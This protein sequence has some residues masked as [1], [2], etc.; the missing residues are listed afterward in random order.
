MAIS[1]KDIRDNRQWRASTGLNEEQFFELVKEFKITYENFL[2]ESVS[3][4]KSDT[5]LHT[6]E[7]LVFFILYSIKSGLTYD[8]LGLSFDMDRG[9]VFRQQAFL[10][11]ILEMT[12]QRLG[13]MPKRL[14]Q[15]MQ[16]FQNHME[17]EEAIILDT[18]EQRKQRSQNQQVQKKEYSGKKKHIL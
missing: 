9:G 5:K 1:Y 12:L 17:Q 14:Y 11:R 4:S 18:S 3:S 15:D 7:D 8:L 6:Y 2:G 16:E 10:L 13:H